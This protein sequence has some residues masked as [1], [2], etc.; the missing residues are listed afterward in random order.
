[1]HGSIWTALAASLL[2]V[3]PAATGQT[4]A[5]LFEVP[6]T[7]LPDNSGLPV[8]PVDL[9]GDGTLDIVSL[10]YSSKMLHVGLG[11]GLGTFVPDAGVH[12]GSTALVLAVA[13]LNEDGQPDI[14][15]NRTGNQIEVRLGQGDGTFTTLGSFASSYAW[16]LAT[17]D[18]NGDGHTDIATLD[19]DA[20]G[21][22]LGQGD[23]TLVA[24]AGTPIG[25]LLGWAVADLDGNGT[26]DLV[27]SQF[28]GQV[29]VLL[30]QVSGGLVLSGSFPTAAYPIAVAAADMNGDGLPDLLT[31]NHEDGSVGVLL[32]LGGGS[33]A[34]SLLF[35]ATPEP[36]SI[37][38]D[39][40]DG[41][42]DQD[43]AVPNDDDAAHMGLVSV[44]LGDGNGALSAPQPVHGCFL[45]SKLYAG[46]FDEDGRKDLLTINT[47]A[48]S[49][50]SARSV[51]VLRGH[52]DGSFSGNVT[53]PLEEGHPDAIVAGDFDLDGLP[54]LA[55]L[56][57]GLDA[58]VV[59]LGQGDGT[60]VLHQHA[61]GGI[62]D[63]V[64]GDFDEDGHLD[65]ATRFQDQVKLLIGQP[66][67]SFASGG[68]F[69][70]GSLGFVP[71]T[72]ALAAADLDGDSHLDLACALHDERSLKVL[73]GDGAGSLSVGAPISLEARPYGVA[74]ADVDEDDSLDLVAATADGL[75]IVLGDGEGGFTLSGTS[76]A[77]LDLRTVVTGDFDGDGLADVA[78]GT[79]TSNPNSIAILLGH[80]D[81]TFD[82][83]SIEDDAFQFQWSLA[84]GDF[85][86]D[87]VE[88]LA[89]PLSG[90]HVVGILR[91]LGDGSFQ[92]LDTY[93][94][95][96][97]PRDL[98]TADF[99]RDGTLDLV[100]MN[101]NGDDA[102]AT[103]LLNRQPSAWQSL[104][105][106][107]A[108]V[109]GKPVLF[110]AGTLGPGSGNSLHLTHGKP[111][112]VAN[113]VVGATLLMAPFKGGTLVPQP[114]LV[115]PLPIPPSGQLALPFTW[116]AAAPS[117]F[118]LFMQAWTADVAAVAGFAASN[119][120][121]GTTP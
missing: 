43:V 85:D 91:G 104:G 19:D 90:H 16:R 40:L 58:L 51:S 55:A 81:G 6:T 72:M 32:G 42:G 75:R 101:G 9:D 99:D 97:E 27:V 96:A 103:V 61:G 120:L 69:P 7:L 53:F 36:L 14:A 105:H 50:N 5:R 82:L 118:S 8:A 89:T 70:V 17:G 56:G 98:A 92:P 12:L 119:G 10:S 93:G 112:G 86:G 15:V 52:G 57:S 78:S 38:V 28:A 76:A 116:P 20:V 41:D 108:G 66:D 1:M 95:G 26:D 64:A 77:G 110:G 59:H 109:D 48:S 25:S 83:S 30:G 39:D 102:A 13:D 22:L 47:S 94:V 34:P 79:T 63:L 80:G 54:D 2:L 65:L 121:A 87:G 60:M 31:A 49:F 111:G 21:L 23:G 100:T 62:L 74:V 11:T 35:A 46:D 84:V 4:E 117:G 44:L 37:L 67:G 114:L 88:D 3:A 18:F 33:F 68:S 24:V 113:L 107:L 115:V 71:M 106:A 45:P 29:E 73:L